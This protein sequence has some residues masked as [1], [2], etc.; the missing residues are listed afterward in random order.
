M[1]D[2]IGLGTVCK[3]SVR[4]VLFKTVNIVRNNFPG[5]HIHAFGLSI[6]HVGAMRHVLNSFDSTAWT[7]PRGRGHSC[8]NKEERIKYFNNFLEVLKMKS[9]SY[10]NLENVFI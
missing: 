6:R 10:V 3:Q 7:F 8:K 5:A 9:V 1:P 4:K 2:K